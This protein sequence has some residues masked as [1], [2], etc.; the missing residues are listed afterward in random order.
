MFPLR[1][2][3]PSRRAPLVTLLLIAANAAAFLREISGTPR[4]TERML[5]L[6][7]IVPA[8]YSDPDAAWALDRYSSTWLPFLTSMFLHGGVVHLISNMWILWIFGDN[9][10]D[11]M[12]RVR[13]LGFYVFC[14][15]AAAAVHVLTNLGSTVPT[16]GA[17]GAIAGV[18]GAY[19]A[20]FPHARVLTFLP[21]FIL[22]FLVEIPAVIFLGIW[23]ATQ[24][25]EGTISS[26]FDQLAGGIAWWAHVGGFGAGLLFFP[27]FLAREGRRARRPD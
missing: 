3:V 26:S 16:I 2:N 18:M 25:W 10:E 12:G 8:R 21:L 9:V 5:H 4:E 24:V 13:Y 23:F 15:V 22:P 7:G 20:L 1:D 17:S 14:G 27:L 6:F 19:F 11:R